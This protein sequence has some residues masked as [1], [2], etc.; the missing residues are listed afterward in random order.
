MNIAAN[1]DL[2]KDVA[3][4]YCTVN[5]KHI[6]PGITIVNQMALLS[7]EKGSNNLLASKKLELR[8]YADNAEKGIKTI[9]KAVSVFDSQLFPACVA[10]RSYAFRI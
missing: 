2:Y 9:V 7:E 1:F 8:E 10:A 4:M 5:D 3:T 6:Q